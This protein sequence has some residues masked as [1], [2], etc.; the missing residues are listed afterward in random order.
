[1]GITAS[2]KTAATGTT[3]LGRFYTDACNNTYTGWL[4]DSIPRRI[5]LGVAIGS[6]LPTSTDTWTT[7]RSKP[8]GGGISYMS[9]TR[10][11]GYAE[12]AEVMVG[13]PFNDCESIMYGSFSGSTWT[14]K[15]TGTANANVVL[16]SLFTQEVVQTGLNPYGTIYTT[17]Y[18][19][20]HG[21]KQIIISS[22]GGLG[23]GTLTNHGSGNATTATVKLGQSMGAGWAHVDNDGV[24]IKTEAINTLA[25]SGW[26]EK[27]FRVTDGALNAYHPT[28]IARASANGAHI[29][30]HDEGDGVNENG[31]P[32]GVYSSVGWV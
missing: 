1:M 6:P 11:T 16:K 23:L 13:I 20:V 7:V 25:P 9:Y 28:M 24:T 12:L 3:L 26:A 17:T 10:Y 30:Y 18:T 5:A 14:K 32:S 8:D 19:T 29:M 21:N 27:Y 22:S 31:Y 2:V 15:E 4:Q